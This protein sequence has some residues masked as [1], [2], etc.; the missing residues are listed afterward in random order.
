MHPGWADTPGLSASLPGFAGVMKPILRTAAEGIDTLLWLAT[1]PEVGALA[2]KF[3][4]DRRAR[5]YDRVPMTR[6]S[7]ADRR[8]LWSVVV[9]MA[10]VG[11]P[12]P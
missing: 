3:V 8:R 1:T 4:H 7:A 2:G 6:V 5:P 12:A 11:D 10:E 9:G